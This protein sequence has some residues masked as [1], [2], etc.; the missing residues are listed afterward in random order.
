LAKDAREDA[1]F[2]LRQQRLVGHKKISSARRRLPLQAAFRRG[3]RKRAPQKVYASLQ[4]DLQVHNTNVQ[5][6]N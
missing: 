5:M 2:I 4:L 6:F 1:V 3:A